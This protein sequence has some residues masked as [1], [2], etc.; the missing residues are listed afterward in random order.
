MKTIYF[1]K[2]IPRVLATKFSS[3][4]AKKL[5]YTGLNAVKYEKDLAEPPL[6]GD[7]VR[8]RNIYC[9]VCGTDVSFFKA[10]T[11][12][13]SAFEPIPSSK[14]TYLGHENIG[15]VIEIGSEVK[16]LKVGDRVTIRAYMSGCD[17]KGI[18]DRCH[19]CKEG[20]YNF[21]LNYGA[22]SP[23]KN[24]GDTGAGFSDRFIYPEKGLAKVYDEISDLDATM[25]EPAAVSIHSVL[26]SPPQKDEKILVMGCGT[27]GLGVVQAIKI[28][29]P[30][31]EIWIME[32]VKMKQ[33]FAKK[34]GADYVLKGDPYTA[35][36][37]ATGGS[38]VYTGMNKNKYFF[39][40]FDR[41]Y[42]CIGGNWSNN[43]GLRLLKARGTFVKIG[44]HM[45]AITF[46]ESPIWWQ[47][48]KIIG[49]D[50]HGMEKWEGRK[51]YT[52]D[53]A[54]EWIRDGIYSVDGFIT[55]HFDLD[56]YKEAMRL[57]MNNPPDVI[58]IVLDCQ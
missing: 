19:Y 39:G 14:R 51:L 53:L 16:D 12:T 49:V 20:N 48:L 34:L 37:K 26:T 36:S 24:L 44:H 41:I 25:I 9:G 5:L 54:Q 30:D 17:T 7:W 21:C 18:K 43:T 4:Y 2:D 28:L 50:A 13:S 55:H 29:E 3:R 22:P 23:H 45:Q 46:D 40:G 47:E 32:R 57:A 8:V 56:D 33:D 31:C 58:K 6:P 42:D 10:T 35:S 1:E 15:K 11:G 52:F 38:Q 27:I